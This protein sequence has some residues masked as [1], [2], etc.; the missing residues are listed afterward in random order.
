[1]ELE[2]QIEK[3]AEL[4]VIKGCA[5]KPGQEL[6][7][8][9]PVQTLDFTRKVVK[10]AYEH[11]ASFVTVAWSD[12]LTNRYGLEYAPLDRYEQVPAWSAERAKSMAR[13]GAGPT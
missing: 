3:Y 12:G 11:G 8:N 5:L 7:I 1:M 9:A 2:E 6:Y 13:N 10:C 4:L